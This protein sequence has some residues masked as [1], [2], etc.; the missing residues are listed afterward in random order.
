MRT[1]YRS[2]SWTDTKVDHIL[3]LDR[4]RTGRQLSDILDDM[5]F[6][7]EKL[8]VFLPKEK[9]QKEA[10]KKVYNNFKNLQLDLIFSK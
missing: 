4:R 1:E 7:V 5:H 9:K 10:F 2:V 3:A 8:P 6:L